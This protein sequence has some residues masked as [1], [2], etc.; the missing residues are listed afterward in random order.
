[1]AAACH[2]LSA[3]RFVCIAVCAVQRHL[4]AVPFKG[5]CIKT[6]CNLVKGCLFWP[7]GD[8]GHAG[9]GDQSIKSVI[10]SLV[11]GTQRLIAMLIEQFWL[12]TRLYVGSR[13]LC[14]GSRFIYMG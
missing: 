7:S 2:T 4:L 1:M 3:V 8:R 14:S 10:T 11:Y 5:H 9:T 6:I 12:P 13:T